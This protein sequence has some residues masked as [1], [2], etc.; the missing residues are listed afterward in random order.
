MKATI[1]FDDA[2]Y[3]RLKIEAAKRGR[4]VREMVAE[5]VQQVLDAPPSVS[6]DHGAAAGTWQP[7]WFGSLARYGA[8]VRTGRAGAC[9]RGRQRVA[10]CDFRS[11]GG[12]DVLRAASPLRRAAWRGRE[13]A[14]R[15]ADRS[16]HSPQRDRAPS[17]RRSGRA[18]TIKVCASVGRS[19]DSCGLRRR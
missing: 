18:V 9:A 7:A 16:A 13:R 5:G 4:T 1:E 17:S 10:G 12:R 19:P 15:L 11:G 14:R 2:L 8:A 6:A 3:R